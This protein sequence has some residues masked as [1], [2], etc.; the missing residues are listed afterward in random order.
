MF[1][2][3][4]KG[5]QLT[6]NNTV[7]VSV[8]WGRGNY[9]NNRYKSDHELMTESFNNGIECKNAEVLIWDNTADFCAATGWLSAEE[10]ANILVICAQP[11]IN[12]K[13]LNTYVKVNEMFLA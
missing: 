10:V 4:N 1:H 13:A 12:F 6:F 5:F 9:C 7:T 8:M 11:V 2:A 3:N